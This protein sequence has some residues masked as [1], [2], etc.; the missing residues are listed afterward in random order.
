MILALIFLV[1]Y[2]YLYR[3]R[4]FPSGQPPERRR[5]TIF[6]AGVAVLGAVLSSAADELAHW[7]FAVHM[8]QH[9]LLTL[10][11]PPLLVLGVPRAQ[12]DEWP[13]IDGHG[14]AARLARHP[15]MA[16]LLAAAS[17]LV[18]HVPALYLAALESV[19]LHIL[20]HASFFG[21]AVYFWAILI[22]STARRVVAP[23]LGLFILWMA[24]DLLGALLTLSNQV[25]YPL[26]ER[27]AHPWGW[28]PLWDQHM[29]GLIMW[30]AGGIVYAVLMT[31]W[32]L[33]SISTR[34]HRG[35]PRVGD[36]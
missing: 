4:W 34:K 30:V 26:R 19:S 35:G 6:L 12:L 7:S 5:V 29:G 33:T 27:T 10:L 31:R 3:R 24:S 18:W 28:T 15:I 32:I 8:T 1:L 36:H 11:V 17:L 13:W 9:M 22:R 25:Y 21:T 14:T 16:A 2:V 20:E 23:V